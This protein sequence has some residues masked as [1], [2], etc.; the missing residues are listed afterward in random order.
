[1]T[2]APE[3]RAD[4]PVHTGPD[5]GVAPALRTPEKAAAGAEGMDPMGGMGG[6]M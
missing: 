4:A 3:P 2:T 6:M 1:M 5:A